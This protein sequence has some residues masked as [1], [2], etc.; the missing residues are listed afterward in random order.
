M[1]YL[2]IEGGTERQ[3]DDV[4]VLAVHINIAEW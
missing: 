3:S 1:H 2:M 4:N